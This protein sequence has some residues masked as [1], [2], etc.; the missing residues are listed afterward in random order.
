MRVLLPL[1]AK[2]QQQ[3]PED[4]PLSSPRA[5]PQENL[6]STTLVARAAAATV[7][8]NND[9]E[10]AENDSPHHSDWWLH[11][12][13]KRKLEI[14]DESLSKRLGQELD[15]DLNRKPAAK[16]TKRQCVASNY[17]DRK[18]PAKMTAG[19]YVDERRDP[20]V[21]EEND[22]EG[23]HGLEASEEIMDP[24]ADDGDEAEVPVATYQR[25]EDPATKDVEHDEAEE[26]AFAKALKQRGLEILLQEGDGNCLF[27]AVS[28]QVYGSAD[29]HAQIRKQCLDHMA[30]DEE[31]FS[32][33]VTGE[34]FADYIERKRQDGVH[35]N[36]PEIQ[37]ISELFNRPVEV[38]TPDNGATP[39][40]IFQTEY[41]TADVPIRLS[42]H[43]GNHYN[44]V[45]DP[46]C[47]TAGLGLGLPNLQPGLADKMQVAKAVQESEHQLADQ[48]LLKKAIED[49]S[50][51]D[52]AR[53]LK[54][55]TL[56]AAKA[57]SDKAMAL[58][59]VDA[60]NFELEQAML[61]SSMIGKQGPAAASIPPAASVPAAA[62]L[63]HDLDEDR[64]LRSPEDY[65]QVVQELIMNG[66]ELSKVVRAYELI[67][68]SFD[69]LLAFLV[70]TSN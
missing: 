28:L 59:D 10:T 4:S 58:S 68:D 39:L 22:P 2:Q 34:A 16:P 30:K 35:G 19:R 31:H 42:Y 53:A 9:D 3:R 40:N 62:S 47:P 48:M 41:K 29:M 13:K 56:Y 36:N 21:L 43:D 63:N 27:R 6:E 51:D 26:K 32:H 25:E 23:A 54:E 45:V 7:S 24:A 57:Q 67:G 60:T 18:L 8:H 20:P 49:S 1:K 12:N 64:P 70:S 55:S 38:F 61:E 44:A 69:D 66:F 37:A 33:F 11:S 46:L 52:M 14:E 15:L 5:A 17:L 50:N 65:P